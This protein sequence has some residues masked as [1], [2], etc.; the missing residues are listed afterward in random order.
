LGKQ[1]AFTVAG[2]REGEW[3]ARAG[4]WRQFGA[5]DLIV[6][7]RDPSLTTVGQHLELLRRVKWA[8]EPI[9]SV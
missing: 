7:T 5:T 8:L 9:L 4:A 1:G 6:D 3:A 2:L